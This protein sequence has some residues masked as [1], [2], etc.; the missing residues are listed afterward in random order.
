MA[1]AQRERNVSPKLRDE[2]LRE[3][4][5]IPDAEQP[6]VLDFLRGLPKGN[7]SSWHKHVGTIS[8]DEWDRITK[9]IEEGC[10]KVNPDAW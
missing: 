5:N 3:L 1:I 2:I 10:E 8:P 6:R 4:N 7:T 9:A